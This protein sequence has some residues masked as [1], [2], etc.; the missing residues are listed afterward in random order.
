[1]INIV[2]ILEVKDAE[3]FQ[4]FE[5]QAMSILNSHGGMLLSAFEADS[6]RS[7]RSENIEVH[8]I[9]FPSIENY[10]AYRNDQALKELAEMR[11][12]AIQ[13]TEVYVSNGLKTY[14]ETDISN[15]SLGA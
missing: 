3:A 13:S 8:Y 15:Q 4:E 1:M 2:A 6:A 5:Q 12:I 14:V 10:D 9:R 7:T 11:S